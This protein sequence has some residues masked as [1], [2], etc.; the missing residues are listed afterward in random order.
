MGHF[1]VNARLTGPTGISNI[2]ELFVD[3]G[4]TFIVLPRTIAEHLGLRATRTCTVELPGGR[5]EEWPVAELRIAIQNREAPSLC[6]IVE[7]GRPLLG[8]V[9]LESLRLAVDPVGQRLV[10]TKAFVMLSPR[11]AV[12]AA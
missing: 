1:N 7:S 4:A 8:M 11:R 5:E 2:V 12:V 6:L 3:T 9:P 10:P